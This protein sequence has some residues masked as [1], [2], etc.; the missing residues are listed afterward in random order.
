[1]MRA[2]SCWSWTT[3]SF[4]AV[5]DRDLAGGGVANVEHHGPFTERRELLGLQLGLGLRLVGA[6]I[7]GGKGGHRHRDRSDT[8]GG[9]QQGATG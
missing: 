4:G 2:T 7:T 9:A 8:C 1:M 3:T 6:R 5:E